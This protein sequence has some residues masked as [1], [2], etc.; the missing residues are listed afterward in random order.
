MPK[1]MRK[2][3][4]VDFELKVRSHIRQFCI[5]SKRIDESSLKELQKFY[6]E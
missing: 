5:E 3:G 1:D 4:Q 2:K 6:D